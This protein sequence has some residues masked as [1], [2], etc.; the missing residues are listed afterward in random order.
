MKNNP[1]IP[2][3][4]IMAFGIGLIFFMSLEGAGNKEEIAAGHGEEEAAEEGATASEGAGGEE[5]VSSCIGC[6]GG[7]LT[8]GMGP[9]IAG[10]DAE[11]IVDV[12]ANGIEGSPMTPGLKTGSEAEAIAEYIS[13]LE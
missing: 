5:L 2:Y 4:L 8:G 6:H 11:H 7:D 9:K 13:S 1:I 3:I 10:L 12:L